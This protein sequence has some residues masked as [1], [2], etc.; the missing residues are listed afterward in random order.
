MQAGSLSALEADCGNDAVRDRLPRLPT[1]IQPAIGSGVA[2][3]TFAQS[4]FL[5]GGLVQ[6]NGE[7]AM[8]ILISTLAMTLALAFTGPAFAG[9]AAAKTE[10]DCTKAGGTWD[11]ATN[12]CA[13]KKP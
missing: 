7:N 13:E 8:K 11:A 2:G 12:T 9:A 1:R 4:T 6:R 10:A 3:N 5:D